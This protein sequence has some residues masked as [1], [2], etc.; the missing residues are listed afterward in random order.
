[1]LER[2]AGKDLREL[3]GTDTT[4]LMNAACQDETIPPHIAFNAVKGFP[5]EY[6]ARQGVCAALRLCVEKSD[7]A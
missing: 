7:A 5:L 1:M 3:L 2:N 6:D 4:R